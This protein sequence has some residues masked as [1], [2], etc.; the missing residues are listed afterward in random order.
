MRQACA[1]S[2]MFFSLTFAFE[3][4]WTLF[5]FWSIVA[6]LFHSTSLVVVVIL[7][8]WFVSN[9]KDLYKRR[10][11]VI[12]C[13]VVCIVVVFAYSSVLNYVNALNIL[14]KDYSAYDEGGR[15]EGGERLAYYD[16]LL[17]VT[18]CFLI[19]ICRLNKLF[20]NQMLTF[21][22]IVLLVYFASLFLGL[23]NVYAARIGLYFSIVSIYLWTIELSNKH[24]SKSL[25]YY[26]TIGVVLFSWLYRIVY[27]NAHETIPYTSSILGI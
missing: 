14:N 20:S 24:I 19:V 1:M 13:V 15:F 5:V 4:K 26:I 6:F 10:V 11:Y 22:L 8:L 27:K 3:K 2:I 23:Y 25:F 9:I 7:C 16:L 17:I 12:L 18:Q 21:H